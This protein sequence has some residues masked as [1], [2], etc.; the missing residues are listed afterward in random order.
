MSPQMYLVLVV[1]M[2]SGALVGIMRV[3]RGDSGRAAFLAAIS[4]AFVLVVVGF[5]LLS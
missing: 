4:T 1:A 2:L 5:L 3:E